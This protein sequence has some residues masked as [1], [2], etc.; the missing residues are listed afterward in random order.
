MYM[1][2]FLEKI[3]ALGKLCC[4]SL[5]FCCAVLRCLAFPSISWMIRVVYIHIHV[6]VNNSLKDCI[7]NVYN[8]VVPFGGEG[9]DGGLG[10]CLGEPN[11]FS[12]KEGRGKGEGGKEQER[13]KKEEV[14]S[15]RRTCTYTVYYTAQY[16]CTCT[17]APC[18]YKPAVC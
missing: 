18:V 7:D 14:K 1:E 2:F 4:V 10:E 12:A 11:T 8:M 3:T 9:W 15:E 5:C 16:T 13:A 17:C 6:H